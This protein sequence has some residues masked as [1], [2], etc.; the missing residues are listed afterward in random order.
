MNSPPSIAGIARLV[1]G[2]SSQTL[3]ATIASQFF[4][5]VSGI[6]AARALGVDGRGTLAL[7]WLIPAV[8]TLLGGIGIAPAT[9]YYIA[10]ERRHV[11]AIVGTSLGILSVPAVVLTVG[12]A[13][14]VTFVQ[15]GGHEYSTAEALMSA[16]LIPILLAQNLGIA[17]LLGQQR[18]RAYNFTRI[19]P[20]FLYMVLTA[21]MLATGNAS[22][23]SLLAVMVGSWLAAACVTWLILA[24]G[25][26]GS[27]GK[28]E[29]TRREI[30]GFGLRGVVGSVSPIDDV[31]LDQFMVGLMLDARALGLYV[32]AI[33]FCNL[34]RFVAVSVGAVAYPRIAEA[35]G[36]QAWA[37]ATRYV[38]AGLLLIVGAVLA[39]MVT[40]PILLPLF[41]G[42]DFSDAIPIGRVLLLAALFL[43]GNRLLSEVAR[44]FGHPGF[45]SIAEAVNGLV[46]IF[47]V[48]VVAGSSLTTIE[49]A[50]SVFAGAASSSVVLGT[51]L[52]RL[53][54]EPEPAE[55]GR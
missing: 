21:L 29:V 38:R 46:F 5:A 12:Y 25:L 33:A 44:G 14:V 4:L 24:R 40:V 17:A 16:A 34:P 3:A 11:R 30:L 18:F 50:W 22:L 39:M 2:T 42:D 37:I 19:G 43:A 45:G 41:F 23:T 36:R 8:L 31:R 13:T 9:T 48:M 28:P 1:K 52:V 47:G 35:K 26:P 32:A 6:V 51:L 53:W 55:P 54:R 20:P 49:V 27:E 7:L 10:K 15:I